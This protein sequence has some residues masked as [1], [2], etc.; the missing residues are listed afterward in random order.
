MGVGRQFGEAFAKSQLSAGLRLPLQGRAFVSVQDREKP[1]AVVIAKKLV[2]IGFEIVATRGTARV[3]VDA[4]IPVRSVYKVMEGR[5]NVVDLIKGGEIQL[6]I[7]TPFGAK[8]FL[9]EKAIRRAAV[10]H[11]VPCI[12]TIAGG[13]AAVEGIAAQKERPIQVMALQDMHETAVKK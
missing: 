4:G 7:N 2:E 5:P 13:L 6:L 10:Q 12:T 8:S 9:D 1:K 11:G 3:L